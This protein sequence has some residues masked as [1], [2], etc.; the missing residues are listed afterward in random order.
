[1]VKFPTRFHLKCTDLDGF[2]HAKFHGPPR[3]WTRKRK[4]ILNLC[5][6]L[7]LHHGESALYIGTIRMQNK[8]SLVLRGFSFSILCCDPVMAFLHDKGCCESWTM[9]CAGLFDEI[10]VV[11]INYND[12]DTDGLDRGVRRLEWWCRCTV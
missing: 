9:A 6:E 3:S 10:V 12:G 2:L 8:T 7:V 4:G 1:M 11:L 5:Y